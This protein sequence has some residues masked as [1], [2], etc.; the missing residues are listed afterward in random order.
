M[1]INAI[2]PGIRLALWVAIVFLVQVLS[3]VALALAFLA[4]PVL[5]CR[6]LRRGARLAWRARWLL[7]SLLF[8]FSWGVAGTPL[9]NSGFA[10]TEEGITEGATHL[11]RLLLVLIAVATFLEYVS[12]EDLLAAT[13]VMLKPFRRLGLDPDRGVVRLMLVLRAVETLPRPRDWRILIE[14]SDPRST[15]CLEVKA[16]RFRRL[17]YAI[18]LTMLLVAGY[19]GYRYLF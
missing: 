6:A 12:V 11:G 7:L 15:E 2:H 10:P 13:H 16:P 14:A 18:G 4:L 1:P 19:F 3:G 17:D 5:G 9:W 8:V